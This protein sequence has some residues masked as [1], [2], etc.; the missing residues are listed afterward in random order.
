MESGCV[1]PTPPPRCVFTSCLLQLYELHGN[2]NLER[3]PKCGAE[4][5]RDYKTRNSKKGVHHHGT[6]RLCVKDRCG[7]ELYVAARAVPALYRG[8]A[9]AACALSPLLSPYLGLSCKPAAGATSV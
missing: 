6:G 8:F 4:Y 2:G 1:A 5:M 9:H 3:C 7:A